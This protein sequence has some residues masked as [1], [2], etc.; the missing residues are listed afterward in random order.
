MYHEGT[1]VRE[2]LLR[3]A[4]VLLEKCNSTKGLSAPATMAIT[5][6]DQA[7]LGETVLALLDACLPEP[8]YFTIKTVDSNGGEM[9]FK[10][11]SRSQFQL[12]MSAFC[13]RHNVPLEQTAWLFDGTPMTPDETPE[14]HEMEDGDVIDVEFLEGAEAAP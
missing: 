13:Q 4:E 5:Q 3:R 10:M 6:Q 14:D 11:R 8:V 12:L 7:T 2:V 1:V 9:F